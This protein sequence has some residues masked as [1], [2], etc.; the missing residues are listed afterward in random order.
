MAA[1]S[2]TRC[3]PPAP[4][5]GRA[6]PTG[7]FASRA[8]RAYDG[9]S[10][11][12]SQ[13]RPVAPRRNQSL[14]R[15]CSLPPC[16]IG[17][18]RRRHVG[19]LLHCLLLPNF[20]DFEP[21]VHSDGYTTRRSSSTLHGPQSTLPTYLKRNLTRGPESRRQSLPGRSVCMFV[22]P[23]AGSAALSSH[24]VGSGV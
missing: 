14:S 4:R 2:P 12:D 21:P 13:S 18:H 9:A 10:P 15:I 7:A 19:W 23:E 22:S 5:G 6:A 24:A 3:A 11:S 1:P 17:S 16:D 8:E 20:G